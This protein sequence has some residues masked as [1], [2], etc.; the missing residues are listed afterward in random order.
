MGDAFLTELDPEDLRRGKLK[1]LGKYEII[2]ELG[3]GA[4]GN[5]YKARDPLIGRL[6]ALKTITSALVGKPELLAR[7]YQEARSAG[8]LQYPNI[9]TVYELGKEGDTPYI[10]MEYLEGESLE[11][12]IARQPVLPLS[13]KLGY[14]VP[15]CRALEYAHK[16]GVVHRDIKPGNVMVTTEGTV[17]VVDFGIARLVDAS[18][19]QT[20]MLIGTLGYMSPQQIR[21]EHAD[22]RSD[23]WAVGVMLYELLCYQGAFHGENHAALMMNIM[24]K[25]PRPLSEMMLG[26]PQEV[27]AVV[28]RMLRKE[29]SERYQTMEDVLLDLEPIWRRIQLETV[30][31]LVAKSQELVNAQEFP[32]AQE[33]LRKALQIDTS[34]TQ[35][36]TLLEKV[37]AQIRRSS[38]LPK[39]NTRLTK[40]RS[41]LDAGRWQ[42]AKAEAEAALQLDS[43]YEP[44]LE[45]LRQ[46]QEAAEH[47]RRLQEGL[48]TSKQLLA[49][50]ALT[51]AARE[52]DKVLELAPG[53]QQAQNLKKQILQEFVHRE[54]RA[55]LREDMQHARKLWSEQSYAEC[56]A[57][58][59]SLQ[60]EFPG[61]A[62]VAK[63]LEAVREEQAEQR[64]RAQL[65]E[66]RALLAAKRFDECAALLMGFEKEFP[67]E[68]EA[69][70]LLEVVQQ[71]RAEQQKQQKLTDARTL[72]GSQRYSEA[73]AILD[74]LLELYPNDPAVRK[75]RKLV[76]QEQEESAALARLQSEREALKKLVSV[77]KYSEAIARAE[78]LL[79]NFPGDFE[80]GRL[81]DFARSQQVQQQQMQRLRKILADLQGLMDLGD[82]EQV[83][84]S[85]NQGLETFPGNADLLRF[86]QQAQIKLKEK[87][88][89]EFLERRIWEIKAMINRDE[90][91]DAIGL[92]RQ[93]LLTMG[94]DTDVTTLLH[95]AEFEHSQREKKKE[96]DRTV[97][98]AHTLLQSGKFDEAAGVLNRAVETQ[99][100]DTLDPRIQKVLEEIQDKKGAAATPG[101]ATTAWLPV[102]SAEPAKDYVYEKVAPPKDL[103]VLPGE[104][105]PREAAPLGALEAVVPHV[106][107]QRPALSPAAGADGSDAAPPAQFR[108]PAV[109]GSPAP[110]PSAPGRPAVAQ[111]AIGLP[112]TVP[113][114][115]RP[116]SAAL[117]GL[118]LAVV[119]GASVYTLRRPVSS[120][121]PVAKPSQPEAPVSKPD[122]AEAQQRQAIADADKKV[123]AG[124][125]QAALQILE[126]APKIQGPW[127]A[128]IQRRKEHVQSAFK[129]RNLAKVLEEEAKL[130]E[131]ALAQFNGGRWS[132]AN[133]LFRQILKLPEGG[134][135][136]EEA[137]R[138]VQETIPNRLKGEK[139]FAQ[140]QQAQQ[141]GDEA[142]LRR[143]VGLLGAVIDSHGPLQQEAQQLRAKINVRL[144]QILKDRQIEDLK[145]AARSALSRGDYGAA[146]Q[147]ADQIRKIGGEPG[148]ISGE[149]SRTEQERFGQ[150][151]NRFQ[152]LK[153]RND[154]EAM[155]D[156]RELLPRFRAIADGG[157]ELAQGAANYAEKLIPSAISEIET[158]AA[159]K[160][161]DD[162]FK[163]AVDHYNQAVRAKAAYALM[164]AQQEFQ[165]IAREGGPHAEEARQ[166]VEGISSKT[167]D[168]SVVLDPTGPSLLASDRQAIQTVLDRYSTAFEHRSLSELLQIY[169]TMRKADSGSLERVF[170]DARSIQRKIRANPPEI[171]ADGVTAKVT[172][173]FLQTVIRSDG[174]AE[175]SAGNMTI[176]L[177]KV[178]G[179]WVIESLEIRDVKSHIP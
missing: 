150:L 15:V 98:A 119:V 51:E 161:A 165:A 27:E 37:N 159:K 117:V 1:T 88:N 134:T 91:T 63:L 171:A 172:A 60:A 69:A 9:V 154:E 38:I 6:V 58:L 94:P 87:E 53:N 169:P 151:E 140:A 18:K 132:E 162:A 92:A 156:L 72:L 167:T 47:E 46:V 76:V 29:A 80:L 20:G 163:R 49:E 32:K 112:R 110:E 36:K 152:Q 136:K 166:Y 176:Q 34:N 12:L 142:G 89:L 68:A 105:T 7:F 157:G 33:L 85:A 70:R 177:R 11:K 57:L 66:A 45:L 133:Q 14:I 5:V 13:Q 175:T 65:A 170:K 56:I 135:H 43:T 115:K 79:Q 55:R 149:I 10:A 129:D 31:Q 4:M 145:N 124:D 123:L 122:P 16:R 67:T 71:T 120:E 64:K 73:L 128:E 102:T 160:R 174:V 153:Q 144:E 26:C 28:A 35:A 42:D 44:A 95:A 116:S 77:E 50:G 25:E 41:L 173:T 83:V 138:Y 75:L 146:R 52:L 96:Q 109:E 30:S 103:T 54:K 100:F 126:Q 84:R 22:E 78:E 39:V 99:L 141:P 2:A 48:Q 143:A 86:Q 21:G 108:L 17:K 164:T 111:R 74:A 8:T 93:T 114:W 139:L 23:I 118:A 82:F 62:E 155:K 179:M 130:W 158:R 127:T 107:P 178:N 147:K 131:Q 59:L 40:A 81:V 3:H 19:T 148:G 104:V 137:R 90:L 168:R 121:T 125:F 106:S 113:F 61:E 101:V 24:T 97:D